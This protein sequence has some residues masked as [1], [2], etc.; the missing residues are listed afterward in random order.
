MSDRIGNNKERLWT[1]AFTILCLAS[2]FISMAQKMTNVTVGLNVDRLGGTA[3]TVG[4][5]GTI[6]SVTSI[7]GRPISGKLSDKI[8][9]GFLVSAGGVLFAVSSFAY[10]FVTSAEQILVL[11]AFQGLGYAVTATSLTVAVANAAPE[12]RMGEGMGYLGLGMALSGTVGPPIVLPIY[13]SGNYNAVQYMIA[14]F[15]LMAFVGGF[16]CRKKTKEKAVETATKD[17]KK[18]FSL[19]GFIE[20]AAIKPGIITFFAYMGISV[21]YVY[22]SIYAEKRGFSNASLFFIISSVMTLVVRM[23]CGRIYD[24]FGPISVLLPGSLLGAV[25]LVVLAL[26]KTELAFLA[27]GVLYGI[28]GGMLVPGLNSLAAQSVPKEKRGGAIGTYYVMM[29]IGI[30]VGSFAWGKVADISG[31]YSTAFIIAALTMVAAA[32]LILIFCRGIKKNDQPSRA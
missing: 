25:N 10:V 2:L 6:F 17:K 3:T 31:G 7:L 32:V 19:K 14:A 28:F 18:P 22:I 1:W 15:G 30:A 8:G 27:G 23:F 9:T 21:F 26:A 13:Y 4:L 5:V 24:R 11:R 16:F 12:S 29:D 20:P